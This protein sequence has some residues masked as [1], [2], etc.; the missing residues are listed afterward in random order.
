MRYTKDDILKLKEL[1]KEI[2][3]II[4]EKFPCSNVKIIFHQKI[5]KT[6]EVEIF[7]RL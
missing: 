1:V 5:G 2:N 6:L 7:E 3:S 4:I